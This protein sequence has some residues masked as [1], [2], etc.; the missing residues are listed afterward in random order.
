M[1]F[2]RKLQDTSVFDGE[3]TWLHDAC[4]F[5]STSP[6]KLAELRFWQSGSPPKCWEQLPGLEK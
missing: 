3:K 6:G 5:M 4:C 2:A 1:I